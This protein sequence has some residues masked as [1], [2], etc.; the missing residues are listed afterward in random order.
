VFL[1]SAERRRRDLE[2]GLRVDLVLEWLMPKDVRVLSDQSPK[3][4]YHIV[5][6]EFQNCV[7]IPNNRR[8]KPPDGS[9]NV[10]DQLPSEILIHQLQRNQRFEIRLVD[11]ECN[12]V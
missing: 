1:K 9:E 11:Q 4:R 3:R 2:K 12:D 7:K 8:F 6:N 10:S 5:S